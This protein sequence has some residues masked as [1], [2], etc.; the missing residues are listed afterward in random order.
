MSSKNS[1]FRLHNRQFNKN[2]VELHINGAVCNS[3]IADGLIYVDISEQWFALRQIWAWVS[4]YYIRFIFK[5]RAL[6]M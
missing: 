3:N 6:A 5:L 2:C 1:Q 4:L